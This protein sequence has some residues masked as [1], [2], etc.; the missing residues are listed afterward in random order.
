MALG[1]YG[2][3]DEL[4]GMAAYLASPEAG[5]LSGASSP[6]RMSSGLLP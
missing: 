4:A 2:Q 6:R 5:F 3:G 1:R